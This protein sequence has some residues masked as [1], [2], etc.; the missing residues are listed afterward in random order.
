[1]AQAALK[2]LVSDD[3]HTAIFNQLKD[4]LAEYNLESV[5]YTAGVSLSTL[6]Y[7]LDGHTQKPRLDTICKVAAA[8]G[9]ELTLAKKKA[10][11]PRLSVVK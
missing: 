5:A 4:I 7:W 8:I 9:Y 2:Q 3:E 1:M 6:Y 11:G 10:T